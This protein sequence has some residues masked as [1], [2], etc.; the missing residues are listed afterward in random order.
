[1]AIANKVEKKVQKKEKVAPFSCKLLPKQSYFH[2]MVDVCFP[3]RVYWDLLSARRR[4]SSSFSMPNIVLKKIA[5]LNALIRSWTVAAPRWS[6]VPNYFLRPNI[7]LFFCHASEYPNTQHAVSPLIWW[8]YSQNLPIAQARP[9]KLK[10]WQ[11][12]RSQIVRSNF[13]RWRINLSETQ[14]EP[15]QK[16]LGDFRSFCQSCMMLSSGI[17]TDQGSIYATVSKQSRIKRSLHTMFTLKGSTIRTELIRFLGSP[18]NFV[19]EKRW[20]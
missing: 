14:V 7:Q 3:F 6:D 11:H 1:M 20:N 10:R 13:Q 19:A 2:C 17:R 18:G 9:V 15:L 8:C 16:L 5:C 4:K 12:R